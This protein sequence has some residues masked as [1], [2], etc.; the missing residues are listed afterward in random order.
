MKQNARQTAWEAALA[1]D[2]ACQGVE[3]LAQE[4][5]QVA[6]EAEQ[7]ARSARYTPEGALRLQ[8]RLAREARPETTSDTQAVP[9]PLP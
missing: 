5:E 6:Q 8:E 1:A 2:A 4:A 3:R 9:D 7:V